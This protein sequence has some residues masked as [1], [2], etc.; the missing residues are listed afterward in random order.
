MNRREAIHGLGALAFGVAMQSAP[1]AVYGR[2]QSP[3]ATPP[4][5]ELLPFEVAGIRP[6]KA[7]AVPP[8]DNSTREPT[9][10]FAFA[11]WVC[12]DCETSE[13]THVIVFTARLEPCN[14]PI[15]PM[16]DNSSTEFAPAARVPDEFSAI[17]RAIELQILIAGANPQ[18]YFL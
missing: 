11:S 16:P 17:G 18:R 9:R 3:A 8:E 10:L 6:I 7:D 15:R 14:E 13:N 4:S 1:S 5:A 2:E 12:F